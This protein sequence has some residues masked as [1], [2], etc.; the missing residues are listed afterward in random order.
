MKFINDYVS[1]P[2]QYSGDAAAIPHKHCLDRFWCDEQAT[3]GI[4]E[5]IAFP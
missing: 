2:S 4:F 5:K 3:G 1:Q